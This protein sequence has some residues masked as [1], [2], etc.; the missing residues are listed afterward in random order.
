MSWASASQLGFGDELV[1]IKVR[2]GQGKVVT[3]T[4]AW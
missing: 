2:V 3:F 4:M 1:L